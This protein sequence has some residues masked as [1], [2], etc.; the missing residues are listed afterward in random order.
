[1]VSEFFLELTEVVTKVSLKMV[2]QMD[3][4]YHLI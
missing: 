4:E 3:I 1:M 2:H